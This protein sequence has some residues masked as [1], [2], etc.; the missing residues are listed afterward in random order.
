LL[1]SHSD[2]SPRKVLALTLFGCPMQPLM[3]PLAFPG[4]R[5][6]P[7]LMV[8]LEAKGNHSTETRCA[9]LFRSEAVRSARNGRHP[10]RTLAIA[11]HGLRSE[12]S[13]MENQHDS[14]QLCQLMDEVS[15]H[16]TARGWRRTVPTGN[17]DTSTLQGL[18]DCSTVSGRSA[19]QYIR[20]I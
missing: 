3:G 12:L 6:S 2:P 1:C 7:R 14:T 13:L 17:T 15:E 9:V 16:T 20:C 10:V 5:A 18:R 4:V 19:V 11:S 8:V